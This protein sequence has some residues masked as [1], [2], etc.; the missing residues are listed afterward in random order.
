MT[1]YEV[2]VDDNYHYMDESE[3]Y[4]A[5][6]FDDIS[7]AIAKCRAIVDSELQHVHKA[8]MQ[9]D[10]LFSLHCMFGDDPWIKGDGASPKD[11]SARDYA[12]KRCD[13]ICGAG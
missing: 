7:E 11:F 10:E 5:G 4:L 1:K 13:E 8:G 2:F 12:R 6:T 9:A 3:R